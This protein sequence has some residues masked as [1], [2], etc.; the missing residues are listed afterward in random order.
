MLELMDK[1]KTV[2]NFMWAILICVFLYGMTLALPELIK[3][4]IEYN[5]IK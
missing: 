5:K 3:V 4:L 2:K 1:S